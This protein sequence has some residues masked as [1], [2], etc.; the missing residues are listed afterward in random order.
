[1]PNSYP[2]GVSNGRGSLEQKQAPT[3]VKLFFYL[4]QQIRKVIVQ[5]SHDELSLDS[6]YQM[7]SS[8]IGDISGGQT[9]VSSRS[10]IKRC[11]LYNKLFL[12]PQI[13]NFAEM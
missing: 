13:V 12:L 3:F 9:F 7:I 5:T 6:S 1:M 11:C 8:K 10:Y 2:S 4:E